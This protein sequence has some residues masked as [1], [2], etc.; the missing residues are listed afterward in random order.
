M[1][2]LLVVTALS[3]PGDWLQGAR[4]PV[5]GLS[6]AES[7][8]IPNRPAGAVSAWSSMLAAG[9][10]S[11]AASLP[12]GHNDLSWLVG[13]R[14]CQKNCFFCSM[15]RLGYTGMVYDEFD[16]ATA[17]PKRSSCLDAGL[18]RRC[19]QCDTLSQDMKRRRASLQAAPPPQ[20]QQQRGAVHE[21]QADGFDVMPCTEDADDFIR[22]AV[23]YGHDWAIE[24]P[25]GA[26]EPTALAKCASACAVLGH[27]CNDAN[28]GSTN[29]YLSC[30]QACMIRYRRA[31]LA[32]CHRACDE[33]RA[34]NR[35]V[36]GHTYELCTDRCADSGVGSGGGGVRSSLACRAG[37][38]MM[39][40]PQSIAAANADKKAPAAPAPVN[41]SSASTPAARTSP[42]APSSPSSAAAAAPESKNVYQKSTDGRKRNSGAGGYCTCPDGKRY[43]VSDH[44]DNCASLQC[45]GGVSEKVCRPGYEFAASKGKRGW[46]AS[47][48]ASAADQ[49]Q[50]KKPKQN[51][52]SRAAAPHQL[53]REKPKK[54]AFL[55][56]R[57]KKSV[58]TKKE[59][60]EIMKGLHLPAH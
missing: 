27:S 37:C 60:D 58:V 30:S 49:K 40:G 55:P 34:C 39:P 24:V 22:F 51:K 45:D 4:Q 52:K 1:S 8:K 43:I 29:M 14:W 16:E 12:P 11:L 59:T 13:G 36:L 18:R 46:G 32:A 48:A 20:E 19:T 53:Q 3:A 5:L 6:N 7:P 47:C 21:E 57:K 33:P 38:Y 56:R 50:R 23:G 44:Y 42:A 10:D 17:Q 28:G 9:V 35:T 25:P 31:D 26:D 2:L 54:N 41:A 15:C